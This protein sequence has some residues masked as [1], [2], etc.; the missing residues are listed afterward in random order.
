MAQPRSDESPRPDDGAETP[1]LPDGETMLRL[2]T[3]L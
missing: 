3:R 1:A 2:M